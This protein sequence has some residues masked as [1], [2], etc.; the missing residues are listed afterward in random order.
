MQKN[1][2]KDIA[3]TQIIHAK[4]WTQVIQ[5]YFKKNPRLKNA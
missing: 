2:L 5:I 4:K 3:F 1:V